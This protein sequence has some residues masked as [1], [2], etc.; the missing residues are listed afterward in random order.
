MDP[1]AQQNMR[2]SFNNATDRA[3]SMV[4][5]SIGGTGHNQSS[6]GQP[7]NHSFANTGPNAQTKNMQMGKFEQEE[8]GSQNRAFG[9]SPFNTGGNVSMTKEN[10]E[11]GASGQNLANAIATKTKR[12]NAANRGVNCGTNARVN[13]FD[14]RG[15]QAQQQSQN[16]KGTAQGNQ[17]QLLPQMM[18]QPP[19]DPSRGQMQQMSGGQGGQPSH[20]R[21]HSLKNIISN[22]QQV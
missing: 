11:R 1:K 10:F 18:K 12:L 21:L 8:P 13:T 19:V 17:Q 14:N 20:Q 2:S 9:S 6:S 16:Q 4:Q 15:M 7:N 3:A 22:Q 5:S